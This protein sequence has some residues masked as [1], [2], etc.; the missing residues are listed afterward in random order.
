MAKSKK[1][2]CGSCCKGSQ[3]IRKSFN[4]CRLCACGAPFFSQIVVENNLPI[5]RRCLIV[6]FENYFIYKKILV[7]E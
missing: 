4:E 7:L 2:L 6:S 1:E 3:P 5:S